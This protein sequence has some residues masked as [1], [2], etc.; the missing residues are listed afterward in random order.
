MLLPFLLVVSL[1]TW[2]LSDSHSLSVDESIG[3]AIGFSIIWLVLIA[4]LRLSNHAIHS[5]MA[6]KGYLS[7]A[8]CGE[9]SAEESGILEATRVPGGPSPY[10]PTAVPGG[11]SPY[12]PTAVPGGPSPCP[13]VA[14]PGGPSPCPP[15]AV[16]GGP[17]PCPP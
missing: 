10:P 2:M 5:I 7:E 4:Y 14:V 15:V 13:P 17:S 1:G 6:E 9:H 8:L 12:P 11:P 3:I 16:H